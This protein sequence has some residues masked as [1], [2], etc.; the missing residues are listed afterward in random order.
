VEIAQKKMPGVGHTVWM[1]HNLAV[2]YKNL[3][4]RQKSAQVVIGAPVAK[5]QFDHWARE[6]GD[7]PRRIAETVALGKGA[8][9]EA[10]EP[11]HREARRQLSPSLLQLTHGF[12]QLTVGA[13]ETKG[14]LAHD[15]DRHLRKLQD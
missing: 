11:A 5:A 6:I 7:L 8:A 12:L 13:L 2:K 15:F 4:C 14:K 3:A 10:V 1:R 9:D